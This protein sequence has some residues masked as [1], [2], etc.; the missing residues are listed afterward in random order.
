M[1]FAFTDDQKLFASGLRDLLDKECTPAH[2]RAAWD[3]G[4]GHDFTLWNHL[5][6]QQKELSNNRFRKQCKADFLN[7]LRVREWQDLYSQLRQVA[8]SLGIT[9]KAEQPDPQ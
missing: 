6:E 5:A 7:Y 8:K 4:A 3:N 1:R 9:R 2:V